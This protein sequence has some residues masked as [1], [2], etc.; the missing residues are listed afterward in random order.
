LVLYSLLELRL[1]LVL[2]SPLQALQSLLQVPQSPLL[3]LQ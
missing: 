1:L 3:V 2:H